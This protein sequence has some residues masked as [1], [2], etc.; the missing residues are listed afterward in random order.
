M[1]S[2][3]AIQLAPCPLFEFIHPCPIHWFAYLC[4]VTMRVVQCRVFRKPTK[5][6]TGEI[7]N[8]SDH[9]VCSGEP[10][11]VRGVPGAFIFRHAFHAAGRSTSR[12]DTAVTASSRHPDRGWP[13]GNNRRRDPA[14]LRMQRVRDPCDGH[15][16]AA[17][18][19]QT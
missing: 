1:A 2:P 4:Q 9:S 19:D 14:R 10:D 8:L 15:A 13:D 5:D 11:Q 17:R 6:S 18:V 12:S 16:E 7:K 3:Y